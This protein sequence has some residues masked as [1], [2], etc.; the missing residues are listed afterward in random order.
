M[1][2]MGRSARSVERKWTWLSNRTKK[3]WAFLL[4]A[5]LLGLIGGYLYLLWFG[6][7]TGIVAILVGLWMRAQSAW[8]GREPEANMISSIGEYFIA[9]GSGLI[10]GWIIRMIGFST[11]ICLEGLC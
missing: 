10:A 7:V 6:G 8:K 2:S 5:V 1:I 4:L 3:R 11:G 9:L